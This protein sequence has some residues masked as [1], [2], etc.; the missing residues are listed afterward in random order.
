MAAKANELAERVDRV[1]A[2]LVPFCVAKV[3]KVEEPRGARSSIGHR[4]S[5]WRARMNRPRL[6]R[7]SLKI[8][9]HTD[10]TRA[11]HFTF[12]VWNPFVGTYQAV[13]SIED[14]VVRVGELANLICMMWLQRHP[15]R[16]A[17]ADVP[18]A[19]EIDGSHWAEV[20]INAATFKSY[21]TRYNE[22][23]VWARATGMRQ[24]AAAICSRVGC[25]LPAT[26]RSDERAT[27]VPG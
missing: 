18:E 25:A 8:T 2:A 27:G 10:G 21:D 12:E 20:R 4:L 5:A 26:T 3:I 22:R 24:A 7:P 16:D 1:V 23:P 9:R 14:G 17:L 15:K 13:N 11:S 6:C 19:V